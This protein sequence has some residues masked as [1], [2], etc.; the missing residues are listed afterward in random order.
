MPGSHVS[1]AFCFYEPLVK[2]GRRMFPVS[3]RVFFFAIVTCAE[4][5]LRAQVANPGLTI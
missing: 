5:N 3:L 2:Q 4:K 1:R